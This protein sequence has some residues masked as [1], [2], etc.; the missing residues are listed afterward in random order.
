M[1]GARTTIDT[2]QAREL[3]A[4]VKR[5]VASPRAVLLDIAAQLLEMA[6][7]AF[8][9]ETSPEGQPWPELTDTYAFTKGLAG[10]GAQGKLRRTGALLR[11]L[12][13]G[14]I[15]ENLAFVST[16]PLPYAAIHQTGGV[17]RAHEIRAR[18]GK[19][20]RFFA[21]PVLHVDSPLFRRVVKHPGSKI[22]PRPF[23][24]AE[25]TAERVA[26]ETIEDHLQAA[27]GE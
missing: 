4:R 6:R 1:P 18:P 3:W 19:A 8:E 11:G 27:I 9:R 25:E 12:H 26:V 23:L 14:V 13:S 21:G 7:A 22:P 20:L 15:G 2:E 16:T 5:V 24:P 17:T 10:F